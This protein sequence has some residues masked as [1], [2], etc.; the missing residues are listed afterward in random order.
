MSALLIGMHVLWVLGFQSMDSSPAA[1]SGK[2]H[3]WAQMLR[4]R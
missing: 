1:R 4:V 2:A 3:P